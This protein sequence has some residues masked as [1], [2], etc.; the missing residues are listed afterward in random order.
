MAITKNIKFGS[1]DTEKD[2][3]NAHVAKGKKWN[4]N[5]PSDLK[6]ITLP[7]GTVRWVEKNVHP[8]R[9]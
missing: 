6:K 2:G 5:D 3:V 9:T 4:P 1:G 8:T 7:D